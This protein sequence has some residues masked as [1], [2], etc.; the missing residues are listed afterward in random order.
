[1]QTGHRPSFP[2]CCDQALQLQAQDSTWPQLSSIHPP[3]GSSS[4]CPRPFPFR[5]RSLASSSAWMAA[6]WQTSFRRSAWLSKYRFPA[7]PSRSESC[8]A[9]VADSPRPIVR[10]RC[11]QCCFEPQPTRDWALL[12]LQPKAPAARAFA[13]PLP[14]T[15]LGDRVA[16]FPAKLRPNA[17]PTLR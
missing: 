17:A 4:R 8:S 3:A 14:Q 7:S 12:T 2:P 11:C 1:M 5:R 13:P 10:Q 9:Q 16:A 15:R 6:R